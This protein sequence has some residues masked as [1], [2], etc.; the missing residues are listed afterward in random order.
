MNVSS[1]RSI[2]PGLDPT[3]SAQVTT[4]VGLLTKTLLD[5]MGDLQIISSTGEIA[6]AT[7]YAS[8][9]L[10]MA[11]GQPL[12]VS[13]RERHQA[14]LASKA[15]P[16]AFAAEEG[17]GALS[18]SQGLPQTDITKG[19]L[20]SLSSQVSPSLPSMVASLRPGPGLLSF[21]GKLPRLAGFCSSW[22]SL[23]ANKKTLA[24][25]V[26]NPDDVSILTAE[27]ALASKLLALPVFGPVGVEQAGQVTSLALGS[28]MAAL[29]L[30]PGL[31]ASPDTTL[32]ND[33]LQ[34]TDSVT[35]MLRAS[36]RLG[37]AT[38]MNFTMCVGYV[39]V[40]GLLPLMPTSTAITSMNP[41]LALLTER[42]LTCVELLTD[43]ISPEEASC[44]GAKAELGLSGSYSGVA[45]CALVLVPSLPHLLLRLAALSFTQAR[46][47]IAPRKE[48]APNPVPP[49]NLALDDA[50]EEPLL[51]H[52][53]T[54]LLAPGPI[55]LLSALKG[56]DKREENSAGGETA[57]KETPACS[58]NLD[59]S[60]SLLTFLSNALSSS[61][62]FVQPYVQASL[63]Q[64]LVTG[65]AN[66]ILAASEEPLPSSLPAWPKFSLALT[67]FTTSMISAPLSS[68]L[69]SALLEGLHLSPTSTKPW[70]LAASRRALSVLAQVLLTR[71]ASEEAHS[72]SVTSQYVAIW[73]R[74]VD[75]MAAAAR[76]PAPQE[77]V[78]VTTIH[79][80]LLLFHSLQL[81][82]K[83]TVN[84]LSQ[85][86]HYS[87]QNS[88][89]Y[90]LTFKKAH[91]YIITQL[92]VLRRHH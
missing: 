60:A 37:A 64:E 83:K 34:M 63:N 92:V 5:R 33:A 80:L 7:D 32:V 42:L 10:A 84:Q 29:A 72:T 49:A 73:Q 70:P 50:D 26:L 65:L 28:L 82:Q 51:G 58:S 6:C 54:S 79:L 12:N 3:L 4:A 9:I 19:L 38:V 78:S 2:A 27:V 91:C 18:G 59:L 81:M 66:L 15:L 47:T 17:N 11:G 41:S 90:F 25:P 75:A 13:D 76:A 21:L 69:A 36:T 14:A 22:Q 55:C 31:S 8:G 53:M 40:Q 24:P 71:Q 16:D 52:W 57:V 30:M 43:D 67:T 88:A 62:P 86:H 1:T 48:E 74:A 61:C 35:S 23:T 46:L 89:F 77:D 44:P 45:R 20:Q 87:L 56:D 39:L 85:S 68:S